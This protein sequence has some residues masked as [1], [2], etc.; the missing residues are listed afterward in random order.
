[1][2]NEADAALSE[3]R[4]AERLAQS[5]RGIYEAGGEEPSEDGAI[6]TARAAV[7]RAESA[8]GLLEAEAE[9]AQA[10]LDRAQERVARAAFEVFK[11]EILRLGRAAAEHDH[12]A[13]QIRSNLKSAG[14]VSANLMRRHGWVGSVFTHGSRQA[15]PGDPNAP[16]PA[17]TIDWQGYIERLMADAEAVLE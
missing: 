6:A 2:Q 4:A 11:A 5:F 9:T 12:A 17:P 1:L 10:A 16:A 7:E 3:Q 15:L 14:Y 8:A 13:A